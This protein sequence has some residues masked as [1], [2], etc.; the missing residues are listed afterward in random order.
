MPSSLLRILKNWQSRIKRCLP[1]SILGNK[2]TLD[3]K[4]Q[5]MLDQL[6]DLVK[7]FGQETVVDNPEVPNEHNEEVIADATNTIGSGFQNVMAGGGFQNILD[8]FKGGGNNSGG[9]GGLLKNPMVTM[10]I[11]HFISKLVGKYKMSPSAAS[12]VSNNLIPNV[13]NGLITRTN[14]TDPQHDAFDFNDLVGSLTGGNTPTS[15]STAGGFNFQDLLG[16]LTGGGNGAGSGGFDLQDII[17]QVT[18]GTQQN[19]EQQANSGGGLMDMIK[20]FFSR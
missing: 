14:S 7:Q 5:I 1:A 2:S 6:F 19:Q 20:G 16:K 11:G 3:S 13:L 9:I 17:S 4:T 15:E 10:M 18:R 12:N 8:L